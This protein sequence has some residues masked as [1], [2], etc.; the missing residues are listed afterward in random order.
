[1]Y[2]EQTEDYTDIDV[3][4]MRDK[5]RETTDE[6]FIKSCVILKSVW[7]CRQVCILGGTF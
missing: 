3:K 4:T 1:M 5:V 7:N 2:E 6:D